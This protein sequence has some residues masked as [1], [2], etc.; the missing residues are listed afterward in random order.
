MQHLKNQIFRFVDPV[1]TE[2]ICRFWYSRC[3]FWLFDI[4]VTQCNGQFW[5]S[6]CLK[7]VDF[8]STV[9]KNRSTLV[10]Q[11]KFDFKTVDLLTVSPFRYV[12]FGMAFQQKENIDGVLPSVV[13]WFINSLLVYKM[14]DIRIKTVYK[15][16]EVIRQFIY[17][18]RWCPSVYKLAEVMS[19]SI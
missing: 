10:E 5:Y 13:P 6:R 3:F 16:A 11:L 2:W 19:V 9:S 14:T 1:G 15:L 17:W 8:D 18:R 7:C 12:I 4:V